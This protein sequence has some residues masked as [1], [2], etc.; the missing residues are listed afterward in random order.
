[1]V[2]Q[3]AQPCVPSGLMAGTDVEKQGLIHVKGSAEAKCQ[4]TVK[5]HRNC[6]CQTKIF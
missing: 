6:F 4:N 1:M 2:L 5:Q 3:V